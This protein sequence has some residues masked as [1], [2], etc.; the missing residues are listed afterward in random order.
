[1]AAIAAKTSFV[2]DKNVYK[3]TDYKLEPFLNEHEFTLVFGYVDNDKESEEFKAGIHE[4]EERLQGLGVKV[5]MINMSR[6]QNSQVTLKSFIF[7]HFSFGHYGIVSSDM[8]VDTT[9]VYEWVEKLVKKKSKIKLIKTMDKLN[10]FKTQ[11]LA[12]AFKYDENDEAKARMVEG[13]ARTF[14]D[15]KIFRIVDEAADSIDDSFQVLLVK[16]F[17]DGDKTLT[18]K[19][20]VTPLMLKNF[21]EMERTHNIRPFDEKRAEKVTKGY[22]IGFF[23][24]DKKTNSDAYKAFD[25]DARRLKSFAIVLGSNKKE[26][27]VEEIMEQFDVLK[28]SPPTL[29][30]MDYQGGMLRKFKTENLT[31]EGINEFIQGY[32]S[33]KTPQYYKSEVVPKYYRPVKKIVRDNFNEFV[34]DESKHVVIGFYSD[35]CK[36][37]KEVE[38]CFETAKSKLKEGNEDIVF[39]RIN[40]SR[41]DVDIPITTLPTIMLYK[42][43]DKQNPINYEGLREWDVLLDWLEQRIDRHYTFERPPPEEF[44]KAQEEARNNIPEG[45]KI[46]DEVPDL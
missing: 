29:C 6:H 32:F 20:N 25:E 14:S 10:Y 44:V 27:G 34:L 24:F 39:G 18:S 3:L 23:L 7:P 33:G 42:K 43:D 26:N 45:Y 11:K 1:M 35:W 40:I 15:D 13:F 16:K 2:M 8:E 4:F 38:P 31:K 36:H 17:D 12:I 5:G 37:C 9:N 21:Y 22:N 46:L 41:N 28:D 30:A 19:D